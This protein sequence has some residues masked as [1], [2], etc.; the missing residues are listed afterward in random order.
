MPGVEGVTELLLISDLP[1]YGGHIVTDG[2]APASH[3][4]DMSYP[5]YYGRP[6][7]VANYRRASAP[8]S[9]H[10]VALFQY[11]AGL[12]V[13]LVAVGIALLLYGHGRIIDEQRIQIPPAVR[14]RIVGGQAGWVMAGGLAVVAV[15][16]LIIARS[17]QRGQQWARITV[18]TLSVLS[19]AATGYDAWRFQ[20]RQVLVGLALPL[21]YVLLLSTR[22]ARSWFRWGTW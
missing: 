17:L 14:E 1:V 8:A 7:T 3:A 10:L 12:L 18:L 5:A 19:I 16:W 9:V 15:M 4:G 20:D 13:L 2:V 11:V 21:L 6:A 22:A